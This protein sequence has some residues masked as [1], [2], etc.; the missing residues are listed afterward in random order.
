MLESG[1]GVDDELALES[2]D[3]AAAWHLSKSNHYHR[4]LGNQV[5]PN[6]SS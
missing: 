5:E 1:S 4:L 2:P 3:V 6:Q